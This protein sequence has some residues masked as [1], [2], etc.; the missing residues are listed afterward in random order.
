MRETRGP[1]NRRRDHA[2]NKPPSAGVY[3]GE[4]ESVCSCGVRMKWFR[5]P[6]GKR[7]PVNFAKWK[8][9]WPGGENIAPN[10]TYDEAAGKAL[11]LPINHFAE[12]PNAGKHR[13][14]S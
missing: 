11:L 14:G 1:G 6:A 10:V 7:I 9:A 4:G 5:T 2:A 13:R 12:C 3:R 8:E